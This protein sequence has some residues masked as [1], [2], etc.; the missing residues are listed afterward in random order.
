MQSQKSLANATK[1]VVKLMKVHEHTSKWSLADVKKEATL[2]GSASHLN[3][4]LLTNNP[5]NFSTSKNKS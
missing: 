5:S 3:T 4:R 2:R 1:S